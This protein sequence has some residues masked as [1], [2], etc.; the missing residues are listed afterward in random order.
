MECKID[1]LAMSLI[2]DEGKLQM[3]VTRGDGT[4]GEDVTNNVL[5]IRSIPRTIEFKG[6][7]ELRG[8]VYMPKASFEHLN[9]VR[10]ERG[11]DEFANPRN[12]APAQSVSLIPE[13]RPAVSLTLSGI[14][15]SMR[16]MMA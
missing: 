13:S 9:A 14:L 11:E 6:P 16:K 7:L 5:T 15:M 10:R 2:Y 1:G 12:A 3:A 4:V 8:E